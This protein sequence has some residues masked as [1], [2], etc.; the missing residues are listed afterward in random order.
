MEAM[1]M[2]ENESG[3]HFAVT[4][5]T[6][7]VTIPVDDFGIRLSVSGLAVGSVFR[8][9]GRVFH[10]KRRFYCVDW[11]AIVGSGTFGLGR[12]QRGMGVSIRPPLFPRLEMLA[13]LPFRPSFSTR[14]RRL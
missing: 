5:F 14:G 13:K 12:R 1:E 8:V 7:L 4:Y 9:C 2:L 11:P 6:E 3:S 10:L